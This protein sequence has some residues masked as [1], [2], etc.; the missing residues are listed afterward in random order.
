LTVGSATVTTSNAEQTNPTAVPAKP[1]DHAPKL[2]NKCTP[3]K[4]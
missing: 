1:D 3:S 2:R 4:G